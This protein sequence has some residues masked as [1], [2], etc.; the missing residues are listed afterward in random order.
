MN[1]PDQ[2][3]TLWRA[4]GALQ[5]WATEGDDTVFENYGIVILDRTEYLHLKMEAENTADTPLPILIAIISGIG[6]AIGYA[7]GIMV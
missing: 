5:I 6:A 4:Y 7:I 2:D 3:K 1:S